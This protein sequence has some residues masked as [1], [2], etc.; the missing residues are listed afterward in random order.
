MRSRKIR[1]MTP[2]FAAVSLLALALGAC[3]SP[4]TVATANPGLIENTFGEAEVVVVLVSED[5]FVADSASPTGERL[6]DGAL[7]PSFMA[8]RALMEARGMLE[9]YPIGYLKADR[10]P[11]VEPSAGAVMTDAGLANVY[12]K[13]N[14][15]N[16]M[17]YVVDADTGEVLDEMS[18]FNVNPGEITRRVERALVLAGAR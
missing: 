12:A 9:G 1:S 11:G 6:N 3:A 16:G 15:R 5:G 2:S 7:T 4:R 10:T 13:N 14:G 17:L 18:G 8:G